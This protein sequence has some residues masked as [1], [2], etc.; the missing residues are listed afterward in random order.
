MINRALPGNRITVDTIEGNVVLGGVA[1]NGLEV[2]TAVDIAGKFSGESNGVS[3]V[4]NTMTV[5]GEDQVMLKVKVVEIQRDVLK[6]FGIDFA[7]LLDL[8]QV[9]IQHWEH[10]SLCQFFDCSGQRLQGL[11]RIWWK[12]LRGA[13]TGHGG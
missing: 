2:K 3:K 4:L 10:K 5:E 9:C 6:Q 11:I 7:A 8:G 12:Q 13:R 1:R